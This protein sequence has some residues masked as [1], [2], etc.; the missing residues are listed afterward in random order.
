MLHCEQV[1]I[2][3]SNSLAGPLPLLLSSI[4]SIV[5]HLCNS[6]LFFLT[7]VILLCKT[8]KNSLHIGFVYMFSN[9]LHVSKEVESESV[10]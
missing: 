10:A 1:G 9:V 7:E 8:Q 4:V 5:S 2:S 3:I 6:C